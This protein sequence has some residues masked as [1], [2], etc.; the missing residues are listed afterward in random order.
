MVGDWDGCLVEPALTF[1]TICA[2]VLGATLVIDACTV[3][4]TALARIGSDGRRPMVARLGRVVVSVLVVSALLRIG[5]AGAG[6][7]PPLQRI[8]L[9]EPRSSE[10]PHELASTSSTLV[11]AS[12][13]HTVEAGECLWRIAKHH[14]EA[15]GAVATGSDIGRFWRAIYAENRR[16]IG[17][18]PD[19]ILPGQVLTIPGELHGT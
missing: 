16:L 5:Q 6:T 4:V 15:S 18:D 19:L 7:P 10:E 13:T 11:Q 1:A 17:P 3:G 9:S 12:P 2:G 14:L 8:E